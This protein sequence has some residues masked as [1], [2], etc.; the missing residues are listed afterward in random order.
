MIQI[1]NTLIGPRA[2]DQHS[3]FTD[4]D[5]A[6]LFNADPDQAAFLK[7]NRIRLKQMC[8]ELPYE[9]GSFLELEKTKK[10]AL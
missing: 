7:R 3:F 10:K 4:P 5:P 8:K 6:V 2:V 9:Y 1:R